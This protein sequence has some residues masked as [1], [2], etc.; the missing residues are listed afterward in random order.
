MKWPWK[1]TPKSAVVGIELLTD[2]LGV[3]V[4]QGGESV[5]SLDVFD[6]KASSGGLDEKAFLNELVEKYA[7]K[8]HQCNMVLAREH[9]QLLLVESPDVPDE[10][11]RE[12]I[13][14]RV[15]DLVSTPLDDMAIEVFSLPEDGSK[16]GKR[17]L[18]VVTADKSLLRQRVEMVNEAGLKLDCIDIGELALRNLSLLKEEGKAGTRGVA[19]ARIHRGS[20]N[21]SLFRDGNLY[22]SRHFQLNYGGGLLDD[23]PAENLMLEIQRSLDYYERQM[24]QRPPAVLYLFGENLGEEKVT[25][26]IRSGLPLFVKYFSLDE[27]LDLGEGVQSE[28]LPQCMGALGASLKG[29]VSV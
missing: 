12:A 13:Q 8:G 11:M 27:E 4:N 16:A 26:D 19:I 20:G 9:Y 10:E 5:T 28:L 21:V 24:G 1:F 17:M 7:L 15:K 2:G 18:Y 14:W 23:L 25:E 3:V 29:R 22:L 6:S